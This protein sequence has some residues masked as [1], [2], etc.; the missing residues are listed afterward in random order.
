MGPDFCPAHSAVK[1]ICS[2]KLTKALPLLSPTTELW[3]PKLRIRRNN[4]SE[5][6]EPKLSLRR[7]NL[8]EPIRV[9]EIARSN[10]FYYTSFYLI[11]IFLK[12]TPKM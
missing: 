12:F 10:V 11:H 2:H 8:S 1:A 6:W 3:E 4:L 5:I 9:L 7:N